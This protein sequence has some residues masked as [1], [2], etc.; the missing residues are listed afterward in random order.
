[1]QKMLIMQFAFSFRPVPT[2]ILLGVPT[3]P[4]S[5]PGGGDCWLDGKKVIGWTPPEGGGGGG[6]PAG[7]QAGLVGYPNWQTCPNP[8]GLEL[9]SQNF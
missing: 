5:L 2:Q 7:C 3:L 1:M 6:C 8:V 9:F 4:P